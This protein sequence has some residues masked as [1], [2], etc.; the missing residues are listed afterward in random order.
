[1]SEFYIITLKCLCLFLFVNKE[2]F[3]SP[4]YF[5]FYFRFVNKVLFLLPSQHGEYKTHCLEILLW[6]IDK[7][8]DAFLQLK[9]K[10]IMDMLK[11]R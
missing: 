8:E 11:H 4:N 3:L 7:I 9:A 10:G 1:M 2:L 6:R 5:S